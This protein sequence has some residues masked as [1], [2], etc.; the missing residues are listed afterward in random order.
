MA[1]VER[2]LRTDAPGIAVTGAYRKGVGIPTCIGA[3]HDAVAA[4][5]GAAAG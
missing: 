4:L 5:T 3:A 2:S 1:E